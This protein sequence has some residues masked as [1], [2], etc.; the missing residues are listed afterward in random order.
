M[1][2]L[3]RENNAQRV[4]LTENTLDVMEILDENY[5]YIVESMAVE[6]FSVKNPTCS[7]FKE[8]V[9]D[10]KVV[11]F[12][13]YDY[14]REFMTS[15][16]NNIYVLPEFRGNG[17]FLEELTKTMKEHNKP[18][19]VEPTRLVV[20]LLIKYDFARKITDNIVASSFEFIV[21]GEHVLSNRQYDP[22]E[23]LSTHFYDLN[24]CASI[25]FLDLNSSHFA[26]SAPLNYDI[27]HYDCLDKRNQIN[28]DYL[29][30]L[31]ELFQNHDENLINT[32]IELEENLSLKSYSLEEIIGDEENL[33]PYI[34]SLIYDAHV[35]H[36]DALEIRNQIKEEYEAGMILNESLLIRLAYL[37]EN[38]KEPTIKSHSDT[39]SYC[40]MPVD[41]HDK[42]CHFCGINLNYN[43]NEIFDSLVDSIKKDN[44]D[45]KE[46]IR[47]VAFKFLKLIDGGI[48][49]DYACLTIEN[50]YNIKWDEL[51]GFLDENKYFDGEVTDDGYDFLFNHPLNFYEEFGMVNIDYSDFEEY[52]YK[53]YDSNGVETCINYLKQ[54]DDEDSREIIDELKT[55]L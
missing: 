40:G 42:F 43:P 15:A 36:Q 7:L 29:N 28:D 39:C 37:F 21:P 46:D 22:S 51:K 41:D 4:F 5:G 12:C 13:S 9:F 54:F 18:S 16:L 19:I 38:P 1:E 45:F 24:I 44:G 55:Y 48:D 8:L 50:T 20:E 33:S 26:Y 14:S 25:H 6:E 2:Y 17:L 11:G 34:E 49:F 23:E 53:N 35:T 10:N 27:I 3:I 31:K 52:F 47:Y 32:I 30:R